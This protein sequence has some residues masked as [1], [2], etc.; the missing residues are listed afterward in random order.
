MGAVRLVQASV[1]LLDLV[2][3]FN[4]YSYWLIASFESLTSCETSVE[5][6]AL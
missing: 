1:G 3:S 5:L 6:V 2:R 4:F